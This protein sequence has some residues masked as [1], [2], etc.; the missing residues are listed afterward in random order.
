MLNI[1][2]SCGFFGAKRAADSHRFI[3]CIS[4]DAR[5]ECHSDRRSLS[6]AAVVTLTKP[7]VNKP[8]EVSVNAKMIR[9]FFLTSLF[10]SVSAVIHGGKLESIL[11]DLDEENSETSALLAFVALVLIRGEGESFGVS[12]TQNCG[13][14]RNFPETEAFSLEKVARK[15]V[16]NFSKGVGDTSSNLTQPLPF[17]RCK[18]RRGLCNSKV[19]K[20]RVPIGEHCEASLASLS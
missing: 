5:Y 12:K 17:C 14:E 8:V 3:S 11:A 16:T 2:A 6:R 10:C 4:G 15:G 7:I 19:L 13:E 1:G 18:S 20:Q 9:V